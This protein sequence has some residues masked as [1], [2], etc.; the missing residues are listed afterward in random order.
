MYHL[1]LVFTNRNTRLYHRQVEKHIYSPSCPHV[2]INAQ[3]AGLPLFLQEEHEE[4]SSCRHTCSTKTG[5]TEMR[6][7]KAHG[8]TVFGPFT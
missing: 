5:L 4:V 1:L 7:P 8:A 6:M 3:K 2:C